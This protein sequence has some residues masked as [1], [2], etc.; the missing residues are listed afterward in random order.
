MCGAPEL[1]RVVGAAA[2]LERVEDRAGVHRVAEGPQPQPQQLRQQV[3][4]AGDLAQALRPVVDG[5]HGG[6]D[7]QQHLRGA[8]VAR[9]LVAADVLLAR[10]QG[11]AH[12]GVALGIDRDAHQPARHEALVLVAGGHERGVGAAV[13]HGHA[14][15]LAVAH[16]HVHA[17]LAGGR[18]Q[19]EG[20]QV[21]RRH[22]QG[23]GGVGP[24][25][26][27]A[28]VLDV[29][30]GVRVLEERA[31]GVVTEVVGVGIAHGHVVAQRFRPRAHE[32][33]RLRVDPVGDEEGVPRVA[34]LLGA[35]SERHGLGGGGGLVQHGGVGDVQAREIHD[36]RL[37]VQQ[38]LEPALGD[39]GLVGGVLGVPA[40]VLQDIAQDD[41]G[42][43]RVVV[44]H[45]DEG[46]VDLVVAG[47]AAQVGQ[48]L[49]LAERRRQ[50]QRPGQAD[51]GRHGLGDELVQRIHAEHLH[52]PRHIQRPRSQMPPRK[53]IQRLQQLHQFAPHDEI[54]FDSSLRVLLREPS[55]LCVFV[56]TTF[57]SSFPPNKKRAIPNRTP[58]RSVVDLRD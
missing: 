48:H 40:G 44:A 45:A 58:V 7:G 8:D 31:E 17:E 6:H 29:A 32:V 57:L 5:V 36:H 13:A 2:D 18:Q 15:A 11:E 20:Q 4:A 33:D 41:A 43:E 24:L 23:A 52:H 37:E 28:E 55:R 1:V 39:L 35:F 21:R 53:R 26:E 14:E 19:G 56:S 25:D 46:A 42:R 22:D 30:L 54:S 3:D 50:L 51:V 27:G 47:Q 34:A 49:R 16:G 9:G 12:G 10:L 38:R